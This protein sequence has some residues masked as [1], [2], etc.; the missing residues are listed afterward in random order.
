MYLK[1]F[2]VQF[3]ECASPGTVIGK[4]RFKFELMCMCV[5]VCVLVRV[6]VQD[7]AR[8]KV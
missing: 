3:F 5:R 2:T 6:H 8:K 1:K 4:V 7:V